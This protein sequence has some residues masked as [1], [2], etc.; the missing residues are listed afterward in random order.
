MQF[1]E[2]IL[3]KLGMETNNL[4]ST[5]AAP[6]V[7]HPRPTQR[8]EAT[9]RGHRCPRVQPRCATWIPRGFRRLAPTQLRLGPIRPELGRLGPESAVSADSGRNSKKKKKKGRTYRLT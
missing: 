7:P 3:L 4:G 6:G 9:S 8:D 2:E 5:D 1:M